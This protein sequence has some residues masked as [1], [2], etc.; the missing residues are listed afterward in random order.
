[1][2]R[3]CLFHHLK[4]TNISTIITQGMFQNSFDDGAGNNPV[5]FQLPA[6]GKV[7]K[8]NTRNVPKDLTFSLLQI[9]VYML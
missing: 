1:M 9:A 4:K 3:G 5:M 8:R 2:E 6:I 7:L